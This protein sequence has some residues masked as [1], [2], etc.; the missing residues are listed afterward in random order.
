MTT[1]DINKQNYK[2]NPLTHSTWHECTLSLSGIL[3]GNVNWVNVTV[4]ISA[5]LLH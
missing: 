5:S 1:T 4:Y 3:E 2:H